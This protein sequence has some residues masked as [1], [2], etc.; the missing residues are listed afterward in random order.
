MQHSAVMLMAVLSVRVC[1]AQPSCT[2]HEQRMLRTI[3]GQ[4]SVG[5]TTVRLTLPTGV[6][7]RSP[8]VLFPE[9]SSLS[10]VGSQAALFLAT[11]HDR[12][13]VESGAS[14]HVKPNAA[15]RLVFTLADA[16]GRD[17]CSWAPS[18]RVSRYNPPQV[19]EG[20][21]KFDMQ[22]RLV[23]SG[24]SE[25]MFVVTGDPLLLTIGEKLATGNS[26][27]RIDGLRAGV[28]ARTSWQVI[29]RDPAPKTGL[30]TIAS[31]GY[32]ITLPFIRVETVLPP[33]GRRSGEIRFQVSGVDLAGEPGGIRWTRASLF[34]ANLSQDKIKLLC[35][36]S[37]RRDSDRDEMHAIHLSRGKNDVLTGSCNAKWI[38][39]GEVDLDFH[40]SFLDRTPPSPFRPRRFRP[41]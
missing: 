10:P 18:V 15:E 7:E 28:L 22:H 36:N 17:L 41:L 12:T 19:A 29:L 4:F 33:L 13:A 39:Q 25:G 37:Y 16:E 11:A 14:L 38:S 20:F 9:V 6:S 21:R 5:S 26:E 34:V 35:A 32:E 40:L 3:T 8:V 23:S 24:N 2:V 31:A 30:R 27:F 1:L